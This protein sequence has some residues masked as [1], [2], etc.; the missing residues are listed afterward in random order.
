MTDNIIA[1][2]KSITNTKYFKI[3]D[4]INCEIASKTAFIIANERLTKS[5][6]VGRYFTVFP[7]FKQFLKNRDKYPH[8]HEILVDHS[9]NKANI[10]GRLVFDFD[11]KTSIGDKII[12]IPANFKKQIENTIIDVIEKY[13]HG[14][15]AE[16]FDFVWSTSDNPNKFSKHLTVK[17]LY[18]DDWISMSKI[19][20]KLFCIV[21]DETYYW[22]ASSKLIDFQIVRNR[23]SLRMV[24][25]KKINGYP[26]FFDDP[27]HKLTDSLI[28]IYFKSQRESEQLVT[29]QHLNNSVYQNVLEWEE[30]NKELDSGSTIIINTL[31]KKINDSVYDINV[32]KKAYELYCTISPGV[33]KMGKINGKVLNLIRSKANKCLLSGK[34]HEQENAFCVIN[35]G[36]NGYSIRFGCYRFCH[37]KKTVHIGSISLD[38]LIIYI[39]PNFEPDDTPQKPK[40]RKKK[41]ILDLSE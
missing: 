34:L 8:C 40:R 29:N 4:A 26:L 21:W 30:F 13:Y 9:H 25:S 19:F 20:Y 11:I 33:F 14:V 15:N 12:T 24:G 28:R 31:P 23:G 17:N 37:C 7:T 5:G 36:E 6:D 32:Y 16:L 22:I 38:N 1:H 3:D 27:E 39:D 35:K 18:F 41:I 10:A 2:N